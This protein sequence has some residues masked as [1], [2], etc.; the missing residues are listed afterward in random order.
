MPFQADQHSQPEMADSSLREI[1]IPSGWFPSEEETSITLFHF[2]NFA[3]RPLDDLRGSDCVSCQLVL[4]AC[5]SVV[6]R[7]PDQIFGTFLSDNEPS[8]D[9][10]SDDELSDDES[11][12]DESSDDEAFCAK[13]IV[14]GSLFLTGSSQY[15][16]GQRVIHI[17]NDRNGF[18]AGFY[19]FIPTGQHQREPFCGLPTKR[20]LS[21]S[22]SSASSASWARERLES[23]LS[24]HTECSLSQD[25]SFLPTRLVDVRRL[26]P[27]GNVKLA[28]G[29]NLPS[30]TRYAA[31]SYAWGDPELQRHS[32][33]TRSTLAS[34]LEEIALS[35]LPKTLRDAVS[36]TRDLGLDFLWVDSLC[37]IQNDQDEWD[38]EAGR[39]YDVYKNSFV[40][41]G[42][43]WSY[44]CDS[45][46][47]DSRAEW[48]S[49]QVAT[50]CLGRHTWPL[51]VSR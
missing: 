25:P 22:A 33:T 49:Q 18:G 8:D 12:D 42:A 4:V 11:S 50:L 27:E 39:M 37:I 40:M 47:F 29:L 38:H 7:I 16:P 23:C 14:W 3:S 32:W 44:G 43:L 48:Q 41:L 15:I 28:Q 19:V 34:H 9:G 26:G 45:G 17:T 13:I 35:G 46:L 2:N 30:G 21:G 5:D 6:E 20:I 51:H 31:L 36:F 1:S 24:A 10:P